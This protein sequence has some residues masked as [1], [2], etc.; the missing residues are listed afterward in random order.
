MKPQ[1]LK[2]I[3]VLLIDDEAFLRTTIRQVL[4]HVGIPSA[5]IYEADSVEAGV[6]E[7]LRVRPSLVFCDLHMPTGD[8]FA[9]VTKVRAAPAADVAATPIVMLTSDATQYAVTTAKEL[10]VDGYVVK[11]VTVSAVKRAMD[12]ALKLNEP[13]PAE[14]EPPALIIEGDPADL[15]MISGLVKELYAVKIT[16]RF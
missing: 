7:T 3:K 6:T 9:Y 13:K 15:Q 14:A 16:K 2:R 10:S 8:G 12:F 4:T 1:D 11:P 5:N